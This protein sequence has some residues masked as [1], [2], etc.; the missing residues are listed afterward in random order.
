M[1]NEEKIQM[2]RDEKIPK[3]LIK[4]GILTMIGMMVSAFYSIIDA[5]FV[6]WLGTRQMAAVSVV[7]P[8]VQ[9]IVGLIF[10][11]SE[12][13]GICIF[14]PSILPLM[15]KFMEKCLKSVSPSLSFNFYPSVAL[16][17]TNTA[18]CAFG[19][20]ALAAAGVVTRIMTL[21][22]FE[23]FGYMKG[24]QPVVGYNY[25]AHHY[26]RVN[27]AT[28]ISLKWA[29][30][31]CTAAAL[32][33]I[34]IPRQIISLFT[35]HDQMMIDMGAHML[36][37]NGIIFPL[38]GFQ[39]LYMAY[40]LALGRAKEGGLLSI[41]RQGIFFIPAILVLP[42]IFGIAGIVWAQPVA[43]QEY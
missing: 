38:F 30:I 25:G 31:F 11:F 1:N 22:T 41:S 37:A 14:R 27:E 6:G 5:Y 23:V 8:I 43:L 21:G 20:S 36:R 9:I 10:L 7:F 3:V 18:A 26:K 32:L 4:L 40:F 13:R 39:M 12:K 17:L 19:D 2:M 16:S 35:E 28:N 42:R 33:M 34:A 24:Y 29:T 15:G